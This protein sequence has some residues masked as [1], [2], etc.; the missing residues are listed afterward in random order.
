M[1][2]LDLSVLELDVVHETEIDDVHPELRVLDLAKRLDDFFLRGHATSVLADADRLE[3]E[4][5]HFLTP[6]AR[7]EV[8][9]VHEAHPVAARAHDERVRTRAVGEEPHAAKQ[10]AR[11]DTGRDDDHFSPREVVESEDPRDVLEPVLTSSFDLRAGRRPELSL[12]ASAE[13]AQ[14]G[15]RQHRLARAAN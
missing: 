11:R 7:E 6:F 2:D 12:E 8:D 15:R 3:P 14:S 5:A 9:P 1:D 10:V 4:Q 13:T